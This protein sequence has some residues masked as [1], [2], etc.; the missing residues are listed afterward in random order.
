LLVI[1]NWQ[2][3]I[4]LSETTKFNMVN[5]AEKSGWEHFSHKAD[6]GIR[7]LGS[8]KEQAFEQAAMALTAV[9]TNVD[10]VEPKEKVEIICQGIDDELLL[11]DW[12][13]SLLYQMDIHK[14]L[15]CRFEVHINKSNLNGIAWGQKIDISR[16]R[17]AV[18]VKAAT[19]SALSVQ[20]NENGTWTAQCIVDV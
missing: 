5:K 4:L 2:K 15:F 1:T 14:M 13:N 11:I 3:N 7:G 10:K 8:T 17:P 12:L 20:Q 16:H 9:I 18:E 6:I 19:Y